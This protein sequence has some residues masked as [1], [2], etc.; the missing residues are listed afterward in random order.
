[1]PDEVD[2]QLVYYAIFGFAPGVFWLWYFRHKDDLEPEP[3]HWLILN[4]VLGA[5]SA[6][7]VLVLRPFLDPLLQAVP[8]AQHR[9]LVDAFVVTAGGEEFLKLSALFVGAYCSRHLSEP[10]DG[11]VYGIAVA[12]GFA[13]AENV[14]YLLRADGDL[15]VVLLR[16]FTAVLGHAAF[17]G[18]AGFFFGVAKFGSARWRPLLMSLGAG[19]A[20][21]LHGAYDYFL[22][23][24]DRTS[25]LGLLVVLPL[26]LV[27]LG[28]KIRW[29]RARSHLY[30]RSQS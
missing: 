14:M 6:C 20:I 15:S 19:I 17:T 26:G 27:L 9:L 10:L 7:L 23:R 8:V 2:L 1:M 25:P 5:V 13:S 12:L 30:M 28:L 22:F 4:F 16:A 11:V 3:R 21:G 18:S 24:E 29:A